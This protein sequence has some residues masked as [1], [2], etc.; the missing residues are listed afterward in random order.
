MLSIR[1]VSFEASDINA[2][3]T[4]NDS[5][6]TDYKA[7]SERKYVVKMYGIDE[8]GTTCCVTAEG[9]TPYFYVKVP[10]SWK[11]HDKSRLKET[12]YDLTGSK[13]W[14]GTIVSMK[15]IRRNTLYGFDAD[16][17][18]K[19]VRIDFCS[20]QARNKFKNLWYT[21]VGETRRLTTL[22][23]NGDQLELYEA[24]IP[25]LLRLF[26]VQ[27]ISPSGWIKIDTRHLREDQSNRTSCH[28]SYTVPYTHIK[29]DADKQVS[30]P[31]KVMSFDIEASSS[32][33]DFPLAKK[34]Y[35]V[36]ARE[37]L[38]RPEDKSIAELV[39]L[40]FSTGSEH[41]STIHSKTKPKDLQNMINKLT[42]TQV[43]TNSGSLN[44]E[45]IRLGQKQSEDDNLVRAVAR[46]FTDCGFPGVK[47]D[48]VT[49]IGS[50]F[51]TVG[52][53][54]EPYLNDML[55]VGD[56]NDNN[57]VPNTRIRS[58]KT[59]QEVLL[60][61]ADLVNEED[62]DIVIGYNIM[63]FDFGF[64]YD[65]STELGCEE[66]FLKLSR[67]RGE[68]CIN[69]DWRTG[70]RDIATSQIVIAS[71]QHDLR[72]IDMPGRLV[73]DLY[74]VYRRDYNLVKY[75]L[76]YVSS[77]FIGDEVKS[78]QT[79]KTSKSHGVETEIT[80]KNTAGVKPNSYVCFEHILHSSD[81]HQGGAKFKVV[82]VDHKRSTFNVKGYIKPITQGSLR[83]GL[84]KDDVSPQD[85]FRLTKGTADDRY[86]IA[87]YCV[88][89]C[90]LVYDLFA[91]TDIMT[92]FVEM[93]GLCSVPMSFL[94]LRGQGIK[95]TS[96]MAKKCRDK[97]TLMPTINK[98]A[99]EDAY[100][101]AVVLSPKQ[102]VYLD[103]PV[104]CVDYSSLY[105]SCMISDNISH[106]S[107]VWTK[108]Y[109]LDGIL[110][111][112]TG[113]RGAN[114]DF[115][116][117]NLPGYNYVDVD[118]DM[119]KWQIKPL[120]GDRTRSSNT[121][122]PQIKVKVGRKVCRFAQFPNERLGIVPSILRECLAARKATRSQQKL[123]TDPF[124]KNVLD[125]RQL[126][127]KITANSIYGQC[128]A[129]TSTFYDMD[130]AAS[131]TA[132]GRKL[133]LY[134]RDTI[135]GCYANRR[136]Q[137]KAVGECIVNAEYVYGDTDSVFFK[138]NPKRENGTKIIG[139]EA[140]ELT[141]ELA[142]K[143][144]ELATQFLKEPHD[145]EYEKTFWPFILLSRKRYVGM[146]YEEDVNKCKRKAMGIVLK[147]R[148]NAPIVKDIY[149]G[150]ID[151]LMKERDA[152][153]ASSFLSR[154]L[155][156]LANGNVPMNKLVLTKALR[157]HYKN[158]ATIAHKVL[159]DRM[160]RR[161]PGNK[162]KPG[163]R[164]EFIYIKNRKRGALQGEKI[165]TP[166]FVKRQKL[167]IDYDHYITNQVM[168]PVQQVF[169]LMLEDLAVFKR[170]YRKRSKVWQTAVERARRK[171]EA[172]STNTSQEEKIRNKE[173]KELLFSS[174]LAKIKRVSSG[175]A[176]IM[177]FLNKHSGL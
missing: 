6:D 106:D 92:S 112:E 156:D 83:W 165:E 109:D 172:K 102:G 56:C 17:G 46:H 33:G 158:P 162:P 88:K 47:G 145:L 152:N 1:L 167:E 144:G 15:L 113:P 48:E 78:M 61:W 43:Q 10:S 32:H 14:E 68:V 52:S 173:V 170:K 174:S 31:Y 118:Y 8:K 74:N 151:I 4:E 114:G 16:S 160:G 122:V 63:G 87:K 148:D 93:A 90:T 65:R 111:R 150:V 86:V 9:F 42:R 98:G 25:P 76:N 107:K 75:S 7:G 22:D 108:E 59:E 123:E 85:I 24:H 101:G 117:D 155:D 91:K 71:G 142:K 119:Y 136:V 60:K 62:P 72:Y 128:G 115:V 154:S 12:L 130:I 161:D 80:C 69:E 73:I 139:K 132:L 13:F 3:E 104:A 149:G 96:Y 2:S 67:H 143:A 175:N 176:S 35:T 40:A 124:M 146:L 50:S 11:T 21:T 159:A 164:I 29:G 20:E 135:E 171:E 163:D 126:S 79:I 23:C 103:D 168:K 138:F 129:K 18:S 105:P 134:A 100:E 121:T 133:L 127:I 177:Q 99:S 39:E 89:D 110:V 44:I 81:Q 26:H 147:R 28:L 53:G 141:I 36:L 58:C 34:D 5:C 54:S 125:K 131:T 27:N 19:F 45:D 120:R 51:Y 169:G 64:M 49:F 66:Q 116:Y 41:V 77:Q 38:R 97:N 84:A 95:L 140:L 82:D 57:E 137:T 37:I 166:E 153:A 55:V 30:A 70:S 94:V 157:G